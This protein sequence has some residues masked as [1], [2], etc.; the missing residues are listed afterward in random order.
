MKL[1][2]KP[3]DKIK[4][5]NK[6]IES[7]LF[8]DKRKKIKVEIYIEFKLKDDDSQ[9]IRTNVINLYRFQTFNKLISK[10][11]AKKFGW[12]KEKNV[13]AE[14]KKFYSDE[15]EKKFGVLGIKI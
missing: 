1:D 13:L 7:R 3:F 9:V 15:D 2:Q 11:G 5:G 10:F 4:N 12:D 14:L 8:D 6:T